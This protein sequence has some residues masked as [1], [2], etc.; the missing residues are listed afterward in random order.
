MNNK[1]K[2]YIYASLILVL[3]C[4]ICYLPVVLFHHGKNFAWAVE[5]ILPLA[6]FFFRC[7]ANDRLHDYIYLNKK[8]LYFVRFVLVVVLSILFLA[9]KPL[10]TNYIQARALFVG[11][12]LFVLFLHELIQAYLALKHPKQ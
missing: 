4:Q 1:D 12:L 5:L 3:L 9:I 6:L 11:E 10:F 2:N 8:S 7:V